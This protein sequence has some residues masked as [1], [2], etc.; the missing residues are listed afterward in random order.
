MHKDFAFG[1]SLMLTAIMHL[2]MAILAKL[3]G[4]QVANISLLIDPVIFLLGFF[5]VARGFTKSKT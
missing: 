2:L 1:F 5:L 4:W 3:N